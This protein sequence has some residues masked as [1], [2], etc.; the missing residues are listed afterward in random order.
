MEKP[1]RSPSPRSL[2]DELRQLRDIAAREH[3]PRAR[4]TRLIEEA[5]DKELAG[6]ETWRTV[7]AES[8]SDRTGS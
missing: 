7:P 8:G 5:L 6:G 2:T 4:S 3:G 1:T